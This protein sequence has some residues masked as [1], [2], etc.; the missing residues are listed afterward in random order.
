MYLHIKR[1]RWTNKTN[2]QFIKRDWTLVTKET[3]MTQE[4]ATFK[5]KL[6]DKSTTDYDTTGG[7]FGVNGKKIQRQYKNFNFI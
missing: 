6:I 4:F 1:P 7:F 5:K 3:S 2:R